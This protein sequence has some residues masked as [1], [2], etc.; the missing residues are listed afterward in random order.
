MYDYQS[1]VEGDL[2]FVTGE[3]IKVTEVLGEWYRG[4]IAD[5]TGIFP[6]NYVQIQ[7]EMKVTS[8]PLDCLKQN[9]FTLL[10]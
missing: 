2:S 3:V 6:A 8:T 4:N 5:R 9:E 1:D 10:S 7:D